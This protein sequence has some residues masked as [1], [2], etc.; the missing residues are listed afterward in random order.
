LCLQLENY[1][2]TCCGH[3]TNNRRGRHSCILDRETPVWRWAQRFRLWDLL[4]R[5]TRM[6]SMSSLANNV[7]MNSTIEEKPI[8]FPN[9]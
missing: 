8:V 9:I 7:S 4:I 1:C 6:Y 2:L 3:S 5:R